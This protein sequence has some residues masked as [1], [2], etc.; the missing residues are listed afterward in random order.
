MRSL[1]VD[2]AEKLPEDY[3]EDDEAREYARSFD[4]KILEIGQ[5]PK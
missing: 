3:Y 4:K 5:Y 1:Q 2:W